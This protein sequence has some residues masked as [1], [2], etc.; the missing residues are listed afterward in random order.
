MKILNFLGAIA[1]TTSASFL[2]VDKL[3]KEPAYVIKCDYAVTTFEVK[4]DTISVR[5][6]N[7]PPAIKVI[8]DHYTRP[9]PDTIKKLDISLVTPYLSGAFVKEIVKAEKCNCVKKPIEELTPVEPV[10]K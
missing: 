9:F 1:L 10:L 6:G 7:F 5:M 8:E 3:P 4:V 2:A